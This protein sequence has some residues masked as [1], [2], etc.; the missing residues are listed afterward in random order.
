MMRVF[1]LLYDGRDD[2]PIGFKQRLR[3][4][5]LVFDHFMQFGKPP[6]RPSWRLPELH[7]MIKHELPEPQTLFEAYRDIIPAVIKQTK[8]PHHFIEVTLP[9]S[10]SGTAASAT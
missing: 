3:F 7:E 10:A 8:D 1:R 2:V 4:W 5:Q 6:G 9:K